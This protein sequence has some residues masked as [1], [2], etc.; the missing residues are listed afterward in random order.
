MILTSVKS[1]YKDFSQIFSNDVH[2]SPFGTS[3]VWKEQRCNIREV[4]GNTVTTC[5]IFHLNDKIC[6]WKTSSWSTCMDYGCNIKVHI[7]V[8]IFRQGVKFNILMSQNI[9]KRHIDFYPVVSGH[10]LVSNKI[11]R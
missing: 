1:L 10:E 11:C 8:V 9:S 7:P 5:Q 3:K 4:V 2:I 6:H